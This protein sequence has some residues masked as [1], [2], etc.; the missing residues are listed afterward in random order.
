MTRLWLVGA[1]GYGMLRIFLVRRYLSDYGVN[2]WGFAAVEIVSSAV[3]GWASARLVLDT[4]D[5]DW[6]RIRIHAPLAL[7]GYFAP[8]AYVFTTVGA[9]PSDLLITVVAIVA[10]S[11][12]ITAVTVFRSLRSARGASAIRD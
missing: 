12:L 10:V 11:A 4:V 6:G 3:Y 7:V 8:D 5:S 2:A 9:L 1:I